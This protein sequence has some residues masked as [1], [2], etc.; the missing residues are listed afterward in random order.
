[1]FSTAVSPQ[2]RVAEDKIGDGFPA[3]RIDPTLFANQRTDHAT[4]QLKTKIVQPPG[5]LIEKLLVYRPVPVGQVAQSANQVRH[6]RGTAIE[7]PAQGDLPPRAG[8][9]LGKTIRKLMNQ[10]FPCRYQSHSIHADLPIVDLHNQYI[11]R[12]ASFLSPYPFLQMA[13]VH[14]LQFFAIC[15][16]DN[17][18]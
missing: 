10:L 2:D 8:R 15:N 7:D 5:G 6:R 4:K 13:K 14:L 1:M 18:N 12:S 16:K 3:R 9:P 11:G 17:K